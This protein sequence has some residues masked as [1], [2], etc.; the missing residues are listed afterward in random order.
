MGREALK[1]ANTTTY[2]TNVR[3]SQQLSA[4]GQSR[5]NTVVPAAR[6]FPQINS[7]ANARGK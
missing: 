6:G 5:I 7:L 1:S 3:N 4:Y 2:G